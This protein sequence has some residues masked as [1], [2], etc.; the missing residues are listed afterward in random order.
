MPLYDKDG[1]DTPWLTIVYTPGKMEQ[2]SLGLKKIYAMLKTD[3]DLTFMDHL[4]VDRID[5]CTFGN[6]NS[7]RIRIMNSHNDNQ[8]YY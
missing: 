7:F 6:S 3:D 8:D 4:Y 5:F 2:F 1:E